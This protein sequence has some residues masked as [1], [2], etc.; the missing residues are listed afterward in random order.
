MNLLLVPDFCWVDVK[1]YLCF[2]NV[3]EP[4]EEKCYVDQQYGKGVFPSTK[5]P[6]QQ[7]LPSNHF[8]RMFEGSPL[9]TA[10][11]VSLK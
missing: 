11:S 2:P 1:I 3:Q 5:S 10:S 8:A 7:F 4:S 6:K 9:A